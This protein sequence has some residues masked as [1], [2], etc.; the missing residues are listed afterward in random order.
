MVATSVLSA[1]SSLRDAVRTRSRTPIRAVRRRG[2]VGATTRVMATTTPTTT[3]ATTIATATH[4][5]RLAFAAASRSA[6][7]LAA[8][9]R[10]RSR[11]AADVVRRPP[12]RR[13][14]P[15]GS[16]APGFVFLRALAS[17]AN[18]ARRAD[19]GRRRGPGAP[20]AGPETP[21]GRGRHGQTLV[22][23]PFA[24]ECAVCRAEPNVSPCGAVVEGARWLTAVC[25]ITGGGCDG[26]RW[27]SRVGRGPR[28]SDSSDRRVR[29]GTTAT[30]ALVAAGGR[31]ARAAD[32]S[33]RR[34]RAGTVHWSLVG[35]ARR[36][37][38]RA[39]ARVGRDLVRH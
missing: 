1:I 16:T 10:Q 34:F 22:S 6:A 33:R 15:I 17:Q 27:G 18:A 21:G 8:G 26:E 25:R 23:A 31:P 35:H 13:R 7:S 37:R 32:G 4:V 24:P 3:V 2:A 28:G 20:R 36:R 19:R 14:S 29:A 30:R 39:G 9:P 38:G 12:R 11:P 5:A